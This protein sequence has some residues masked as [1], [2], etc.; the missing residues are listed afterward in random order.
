MS[1]RDTQ[2]LSA[3]GWEPASVNRTFPQAPF[4]NLY[5][6]ST[7]TLSLYNPFS[8]IHFPKCGR[9]RAHASHW[10]SSHDF[11]WGSWPLTFLHNSELHFA[12]R[13]MKIRRVLH[14]ASEC[15]I[16]SG[17][18]IPD[19]DGNIVTCN[20]PVPSDSLFKPSS[21]WPVGL[22]QVI[23]YL[24]KRE[25]AVIATR[26]AVFVMEGARGSGAALAE[27]RGCGELCLHSRSQVNSE[28]IMKRWCLCSSSRASSVLLKPRLCWA[29][30]CWA[31]LQQYSSM[32]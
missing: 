3:C 25:E 4:F 6:L 8:C 15:P 26:Q 1:R 5:P 18:Q 27:G 23:K 17:L 21:G 14:L 13:A 11:W 30:F 24:H 19:N 16:V 22:L 32:S 9:T 12:N 7:F 20:I 28:A 2:G 31:V 10:L 29:E